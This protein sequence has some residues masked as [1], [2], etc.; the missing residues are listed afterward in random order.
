MLPSVRSNDGNM[1]IT[2]KKD[3]KVRQFETA[4]KN[5]ENGFHWMELNNSRIVPKAFAATTH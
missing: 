5:V 3:G 2:E 4:L 1:W